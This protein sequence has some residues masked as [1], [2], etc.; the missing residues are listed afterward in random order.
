MAICGF[1][2]SLKCLPPQSGNSSA[3]KPDSIDTTDILRSVAAAL[4]IS[5]KSVELGLSIAITA[6]LPLDRLWPD[7]T[8]S[9]SI[10]LTWIFCSKSLAAKATD[11]S[12][13]PS[14]AHITASL[15]TSITSGEGF[16]GFK[17]D[18]I[19]WGTVKAGNPYIIVRLNAV[20]SYIIDDPFLILFCFSSIKTSSS[21][22][23]SNSR[24]A[25]IIGASGWLFGTIILPTG[26]VYSSSITPFCFSAFETLIG[27]SFLN[28]WISWA[29]NFSA[30][31]FSLPLLSVAKI[32]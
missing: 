12:S 7:K 21:I 10:I 28:I 15:L 16:Q 6:T 13:L 20:V 23:A 31:T 27:L 30:S 17:F 4:I 18:L 19:S 29:I 25:D 8:E 1:L 14:T 24:I 22:S 9:L 11:L 3:P 32:T 5:C 26:I 2:S